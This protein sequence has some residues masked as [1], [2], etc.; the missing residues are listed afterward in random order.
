MLVLAMCLSLCACG[1]TPEPTF[2]HVVISPSVETGAI[3]GEDVEG[4]S[5]FTAFVYEGDP[6]DAL[7]VEEVV[8]MPEYMPF[9]DSIYLNWKMKI[10]NTSGEDI[11]MKESSMRVWYRYLDE[12]EDSMYELHG[13]AGYSST[14]KDGRAEWIEVSGIPA[15][16]TNKEVYNIAYIEIYAYTISL[17]GSPDYE[18]TEPVL[19][20]VRENFDWETVKNNGIAAYE[21]MMTPNVEVFT[22]P[23]G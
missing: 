15:E 2:N 4:T 9:D 10:R 19:I 20:D 12:N 23:V 7:T 8:L 3:T 22:I 14:V 13:T 11:P 6:V 16:W 17:H 1:K 21:A 18:F 5:Q